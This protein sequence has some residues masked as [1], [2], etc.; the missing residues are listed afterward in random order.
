MTRLRLR[1][2]TGSRLTVACVL[3]GFTVACAGPQEPLSVGVSEVASDIVLGAPPAKPTAAPLPLP[4]NALPVPRSGFEPL[5]PPPPLPERPPVVAPVPCPSANPLSAPTLIAPGE[6]T[7]PPAPATYAYRNSGTYEVSGANAVKGRFPAAA[8]RTV[9]AVASDGAGG[10][11]YEVRAVLGTTATT[12]S[13]LLTPGAAGGVWIQKVRTQ[14]Y[15]AKTD[16]QDPKAVPV[17]ES[18]FDPTPDLQLLSFPMVT[19][20]EVTTRSVDTSTGRVVAL[21]STVQVKGRTDVCGTL[22]DTQV[23]RVDG[24]IGTCPV[25]E[26]PS[27][28]P[29]AVPSSSPAPQPRQCDLSAATPAGMLETFV[30]TYHVATQYGGL[31]VQDEVRVLTETPTGNVARTNSATLNRVPLPA[32][33]PTKA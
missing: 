16:P 32:A 19:G 21:R 22:L 17:S 27:E 18:A 9:R 29:P 26:R 24:E 4:P 11:T 3:L 10:F 6:V 30:G 8:T 33:P 1:G 20:A 31:V 12:T 25:V 23:I 15:D 5:P 14:E 28:V 2:V 13:Y 7:L